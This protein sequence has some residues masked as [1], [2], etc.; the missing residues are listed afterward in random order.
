MSCSRPSH[1]RPFSENLRHV[2]EQ[3]C[4]EPSG[5]TLMRQGAAGHSPTCV[6]SPCSV[7]GIPLH[8]PTTV[9]SQLVGLSETSDPYHRSKDVFLILFLQQQKHISQQ[10]S[11]DICRGQHTKE[12]LSSHVAKGLG[13][14]S[15]PRYSGFLFPEVP[16]LTHPFPMF[17]SSGIQH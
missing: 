15:A 13:A 11:K 6:P 4:L 17:L 8:G 16:I 7:M 2:R 3:D 10:D 9:W 1:L 5:R 14:V 12:N